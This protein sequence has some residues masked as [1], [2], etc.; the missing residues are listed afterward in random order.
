MLPDWFMD[1]AAA[2]FIVL[3]EDKPV[4]FAMLGE[5]WKEGISPR[6]AELLA[7]GVEPKRQRFGLGGLLMA[8]IENEAQERGVR[9][10]I[11]HTAVE[12]VAAQELFKKSDFAVAEFKKFFYP[13]GQDAI[14]MYREI[15]KERK[16]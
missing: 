5:P 10:L 4:A 3:I 2:T 6:T 1:G 12:N 9:L 11:L 13:N 8:Q 14:M 7:I 15:G 16:G